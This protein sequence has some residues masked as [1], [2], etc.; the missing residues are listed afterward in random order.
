MSDAQWYFG[1]DGAQGG[2]VSEQEVRR[3]LV[4]GELRGTDLVWRDGMGEWQPAARVV[5]FASVQHA[6][7]PPLPPTTGFASP[8][9]ATTYPTVGYATPYRPGASPNDPGQSAGMRMLIPVGRSGWAIASGYLGLL[10]V[11][12][13]IGALFGVAALITG[14]F[15]IR[16]IRTNPQRHGLG[17]AIFGIIMGALFTLLWGFAFIGLAARR[18]W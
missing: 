14:I 18:G 16:D 12:P 1:R 10:A 11:L 8:A 6:G 5:E 7:P 13:F 4:A 3:M 17:R 9:I 2:P 15:A